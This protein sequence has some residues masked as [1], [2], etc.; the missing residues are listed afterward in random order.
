LTTIFPNIISLL[1]PFILAFAV[2]SLANPVA[3][4]LKKKFRFKKI[5]ATSVALLFI[6]TVVSGLITLVVNR[7][8]TELTTLVQTIP[9]FSSFI[10]EKYNEL[11]AQWELFHKSISPEFSQY[12]N[13]F[14]ADLAKSLSDVLA[15]L[16]RFTINSATNIATRIPSVLIFIVAFVLSS[17]FITNDYDLIKQNL[18]NQFPPK[19]REKISTIKEYANIAFKK[20]LK[21]MLTIMTITFFELL[22]G[23]MILSIEYAFTFALIIAIIDVL[24]IFGTGTILI[25]WGIISLIIGNYPL[26]IGL[27]V[28]YAII[29]IVRQFIEPK[30]ISNSLGT[31]PLLTMIAIYVGFKLFGIVGMIC[32][33]ILVLIFA[34]LNKSGI[35]K[36]W[37][38]AQ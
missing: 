32:M 21:G 2:A 4:F 14:L 33:P 23:M 30:I 27:L 16:T 3:R 31:N 10:T 38:S 19:I 35:I 6:L 7:L 17:I 13:E 12:A 1:L 29:T 15:T 20:Y 11:S 18:A 34:S 25:P 36:I 24:P 5:L 28:L 37:N 26:G 22:I 8:I 9:D